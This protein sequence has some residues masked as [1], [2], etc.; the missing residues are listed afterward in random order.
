MTSVHSSDLISSSESL[1]LHLDRSVLNT[2]QE[3]E[4]NERRTKDVNIENFQHL[5][6]MALE[7]FH[8]FMMHKIL[9]SVLKL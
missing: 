6:G 4:E 2:T 7:I 3:R 5:L 8:N 9:Q 1:S